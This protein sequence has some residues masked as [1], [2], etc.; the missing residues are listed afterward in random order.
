MAHDSATRD[1][2]GTPPGFWIIWLTVATDLIGFGIV[3]PLLPLFA[4]EFGAGA[5][6]AT[7]LVASYSAAQFAAAPL[8]GRLSDRIGRKPVLVCSLIGTAI[9]YAITASANVVWVL[10]AG[11]IIDGLSGSTFGVAQASV[12]DVAEPRDRPRLLGLLGAAFGLGFV[13]GP[14]M[15]GL[16]A[17]GGRRLPFIVAAVLSGANA[18]AAIIRVPETAK[19]SG[20]AAHTERS[21]LPH[22]DVIRHAGGSALARLALLGLLGTIAFSGFES[23]FSLLLDRRFDARHGVVYALFTAIGLAMVVMQARVIGQVSQRLGGSEILRVAFVASGIGYVLLAIDGR[24]VSLGFALAFL[25]IGQGL[26]TPT[27]SSV[28][29]GAVDPAAR[30]EAF[31]VQQSASAL[32]RIAGPVLAGL[33]F[34]HVAV[35]SPYIVAAVLAMI[36]WVCVPRGVA[37]IVHR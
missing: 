29:A 36:A 7:T 13:A 31:G 4:K 1:P 11:R 8:W 20:V 3:L 37:A 14:I 18:I 22:L 24:W 10:F 32:G 34:G 15:G 12:I 2:K 6:M 27:L 25:V 33:L 35:A 28:T 23:T 21:W 5:L 26:F 19:R 17:I 30:G 9:G 16:A